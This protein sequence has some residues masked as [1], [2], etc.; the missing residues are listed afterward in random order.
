MKEVK[1]MSEDQG[2]VK[3]LLN[4][5]IDATNMPSEECGPI[6]TNTEATAMML[7]ALRVYTY[8]AFGT[9]HPNNSLMPG[10]ARNIYTSI[11]NFNSSPTHGKVGD[12]ITVSIEVKNTY[13][14]P[15]SIK[16]GMTYEI[17]Q[18]LYA[19]VSYKTSTIGTVAAGQSLIVTGTFTMPANDCT[20]H[21]Y[22]YYYGTDG[23]YHEEQGVTSM[24]VLDTLRGDVNGDGVVDQADKD[25]VIRIIQELPDAVTELPYSAAIMARA[26]VNGNG[27]VDIGDIVAINT[28]IAAGTI[29]TA[30]C[31][32]DRLEASEFGPDSTYILAYGVK[33]T[34]TPAA[35]GYYASIR[36]RSGSSIGLEWSFLGEELHNYVQLYTQDGTGTVLPAGTYTVEFKTLYTDWQATGLTVTGLSTDPSTPVTFSVGIINVP[37]SYVTSDGFKYWKLS[38]WDP[39]TNTWT[40]EIYG[41]TGSRMAVG[42]VNTPGTVSVRLWNPSTQS[43]GG[44]VYSNSFNPVNG[45]IY[46]FNY[47]TSYIS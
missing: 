45:G 8:Y 23:V 39:V 22:S 46:T 13:S 4:N 32:I 21:G 29:Y 18:N 24:V 30:S 41:T 6:P 47:S 7:Q 20:I 44:F 37:A 36:L 12:L 19:E 5:L 27:V 28:I 15:V 40:A 31:S 34:L 9:A 33:V 10:G 14:G 16:A 38:Y 42:P 17:G 3:D 43:W 26:D 35:N 25:I 11:L 2:L 1:L